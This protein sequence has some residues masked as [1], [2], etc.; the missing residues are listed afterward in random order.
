MAT[1]IIGDIQGCHTQLEA[2]LAE[3]NFS[4]A[5][6]RLW[7]VGDLVNR[8]PD[9]LATLRWVAGMGDVVTAVLANH[10]IHLLARAAAVVPAKKNDT[11]DDILQAPDREALLDWLRF[12]PLLHHNDQVAMVHAG[13]H[14]HW[15][16]ATARGFASE[17][18]SIL[19][20]ATWRT[21]I[22]DLIG[23]APRWSPALQGSKR[24][25]AMLAYFTRVRVCFADASINSDFDGPFAD[26]PRGCTAWFDLPNPAWATHH[27]I[28][29]HWAALGLHRTARTLAIDTGCVW[30]QR[31]T[32]VRL[33]DNQ[34]FS[35]PG[36]IARNANN[37]PN[38]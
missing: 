15:T 22:V 4:P 5:H 2:L 14:P 34:I 6:D 11:L 13:L 9:S 27:V 1:Y 25:R 29:G 17:I 18:E 26:M 33:D 12:R 3:I 24:W 21:D 36:T 19:R 32:A 10:D 37:N 28:T 16:I 31:L 23:P 7:L 20:A 30:G 38:D 8:G 35:V